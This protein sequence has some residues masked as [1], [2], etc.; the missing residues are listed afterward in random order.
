M[1]SPFVIGLIKIDKLDLLYPI[2]S[3]VSDDL[4]N[5]SPCRFY[6]PM[7]NQVGNLCIA[8]HNKTNDKMF[9]KLDLLN[10]GEKIEIYDLNG[11]CINY[12]VYDINNIHSNDTS[13]MNQNTNGKREIC[14]I[15]CNNIKD[16]R[17]L[18]KS[19]EEGSI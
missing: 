5:I 17:L 12:I 6:G 15:T 16:S 1:S 8:G 2:L 11:Y 18:I 9:G 10:I 14:L 7:P 13:C 3:T 19:I 4:L